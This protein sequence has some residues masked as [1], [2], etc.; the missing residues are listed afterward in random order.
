MANL[1]DAG[2]NIARV[3]QTRLHRELVEQERDE[4]IARHKQA[5]AV[6]Q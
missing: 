2:A 5:I 6:A 4:R 1:F 3:E